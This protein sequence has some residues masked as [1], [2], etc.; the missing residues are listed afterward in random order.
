MTKQIALLGKVD[1]SC[2]MTQM[3]NHNFHKKFCK[4][5]CLHV[6]TF[7]KAKNAE[8]KSSLTKIRQSLNF[9]VNTTFCL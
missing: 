2:K 9:N 1:R 6:Q 8:K 3:S 7:R 4:V 5:L